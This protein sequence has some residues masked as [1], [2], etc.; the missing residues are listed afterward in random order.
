MG[1]G[2]G[3]MGVGSWF[4]MGTGFEEVE[5]IIGDWVLTSSSGSFTFSGVVNE[6][7]VYMGL[8]IYW[9]CLKLYLLFFNYFNFLLL[10]L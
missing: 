4:L 6:C 2:D 7:S 8:V 10:S 5:G 9:G 3:C 1:V